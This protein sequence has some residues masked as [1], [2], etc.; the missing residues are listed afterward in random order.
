MKAMAAM[1]AT[2][3]MKAKAGALTTAGD[4]SSVAK[5]TKV[6]PKDAAKALPMKAMAATSATKTTKGKKARLWTTREIYSMNAPPPWPIPW[7][8]AIDWIDRFNPPEDWT[9]ANQRWKARALEV[10]KWL[11]E[12]HDS[13]ARKAAKILKIEAIV[14]AFWK[15]YGHKLKKDHPGVIAYMNPNTPP[16]P[17]PFTEGICWIDTCELPEDYT[18]AEQRR[19]ADALEVMHGMFQGHY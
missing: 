8:K 1:R 6:K 7:Y 11:F 9:K 2:K 18:K 13:E 16:W 12:G 17:I 15:K 3:A 14:A 19:I 4:S 5:S 10:M